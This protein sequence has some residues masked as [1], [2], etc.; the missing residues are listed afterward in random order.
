MNFINFLKFIYKVSGLV[1]LKKL[2]V[3]NF[4]R[5][6]RKNS[7]NKYQFTSFYLEGREVFFGYYDISPISIDNKLILSMSIKKNNK[8]SSIIDVG[9]F[10]INNPKIFHKIGESE[11]WC[12]QQG[13][14]LR[15]SKKDIS[16][17]IYN[18]IVDNNYGAV[19][20]NI[21]SKEIIKKINW[22]IY[23]INSDETYGLSLNFSRLN[24]LRPGYG[25]SCFDDLSFSDKSPSNDGIFLIDILKN[26]SKLILS[27]NYLSKIDP[28]Q[29]M[30]DADHY[31]N[32]LSWNP[33]G[34]RF[35]FF[36]LWSN[37]KRRYS[38]L[39]TCDKN[40][41]D[42]FLLENSEN[43]SHYS[44]KNDEEIIMTTHS[45]K[46]GV[47]YSIYHDNTNKRE[48]IAEDILNRDGHP[49]YQSG[50]ENIFISDTYPD[51]YGERKLFLFNIENNK[52]YILGKFNSPLKYR[53]DYRCDLHPRWNNDGT[54]VSFDSTHTNIRTLNIIKIEDSIYS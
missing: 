51:K 53:S 17:I 34:N 23:D 46:Q 38:R 10:N 7:V 4:Y 37:P 2:I 18:R 36:H 31:I 14:R 27:L 29:S 6:F 20:Q 33:S 12:W 30:I 3:I 28:H 44:W 9:F 49:S 16:N 47:R 50:K 35:L 13:S 21:N 39:F 5:F 40:G 26:K 48:I 11:S 43:V 52:E 32:H 45:K 25:Y 54:L 42:L 41:K 15:W 8:K 22:P 19:I 24:R 1:L